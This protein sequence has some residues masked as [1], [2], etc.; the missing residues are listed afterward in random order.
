[1]WLSLACAAALLMPGCESYT[2]TTVAPKSAAN[3]AAAISALRTIASAQATYQA[4]NS[5]GE[6][7]TFED[8]VKGGQLDVRFSGPQ[9]VVGGYVL[10]MITFPK[11]NAGGPNPSYAVTADPQAGVAAASTGNRHFYL[12]STGVIRFNKQQT[13]TVSDPALGN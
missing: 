4:S 10:N 1:V 12:D 2:N 6:Y 3:E 9:P 13:A 5:E 8:L 11:N 7:G